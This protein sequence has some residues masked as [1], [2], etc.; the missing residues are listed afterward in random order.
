MYKKSLNRFMTAGTELIAINIKST[1]YT[2]QK[3]KKIMITSLI[4][5][6]YY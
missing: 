4:R 2:N 5:H 3:S 1:D 6:T